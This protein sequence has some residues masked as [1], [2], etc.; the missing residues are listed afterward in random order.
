MQAILSV[1]KNILTEKKIVHMVIFYGTFILLSSHSHTVTVF[2]FI[3][4]PRLMIQILVGQS[5]LYNKCSRDYRMDFNRDSLSNCSPE[6]SAMKSWSLSDCSLS[7]C[8]AR[9]DQAMSQSSCE[10]TET[11]H[12]SHTQTQHA[13]PCRQ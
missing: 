8:L 5:G 4:I 1:N 10:T 9:T 13:L 11:S 6:F 3:Q 12:A 7:D 2:L